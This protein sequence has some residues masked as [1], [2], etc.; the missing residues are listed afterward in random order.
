MWVFQVF[1]KA[2]LLSV[3]MIFDNG[4]LGGN[5]HIKGLKTAYWVRLASFYGQN[6]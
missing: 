1:S 2:N 6:Q 3:N 5:Q 4:V